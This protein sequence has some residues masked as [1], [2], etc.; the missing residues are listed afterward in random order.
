MDGYTMV[1]LHHNLHLA[2]FQIFFFAILSEP[3]FGQTPLVIQNLEPAKTGVPNSFQPSALPPISGPATSGPS[4]PITLQSIPAANPIHSPAEQA[5]PRVKVMPMAP[6]AKTQQLGK[7][8]LLDV[9]QMIHSPTNY[10]GVFSRLN[11]DRSFSVDAPIAPSVR[12]QQ[13]DSYGAFDWSPSGYCWQS[14]AFCF[15]PLYFEQP[16]LERYGQSKGPILAPALSATYFFGQ[17]TTLPIR[18]LWQPPWSCSCTLGH[19]RPGDCAP[20]QRRP[21]IHNNTINNTVNAPV[22]VQISDQ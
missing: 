2:I 12:N 9:Q 13:A 19:H 22:A 10:V 5:V 6:A 7:K 20:I 8:G 1:T 11:I 14:P 16:N 3:S 21:T 15:S 17:V 4:T 18:S